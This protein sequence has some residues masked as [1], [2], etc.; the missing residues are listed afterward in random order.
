MKNFT[1]TKTRQNLDSWIQTNQQIRWRS[2]QLARRFRLSCHDREDLFQNMTLDVVRAMRKYDPA[3]ASTATY[4]S[5]VLDKSFLH[6]GRRLA[7]SNACSR[8][9]SCNQYTLARDQ[10]RVPTG[11]D[12]LSEAERAEV[13]HVVHLLPDKLSHLASQ[14]STRS[15]VEIADSIDVHRGTIYRQLKKLRP[16]FRGFDPNCS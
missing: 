7:K 8:T 1:G 16:H 12:R 5:R 15:V 13:R 4:I 14:L 11:E 3:R 6:H 10:R 9:V 2:D